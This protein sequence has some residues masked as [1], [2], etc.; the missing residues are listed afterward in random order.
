MFDPVSIEIVCCTY[1]LDP[2]FSLEKTSKKKIEIAYKILSELHNLIT[3]GGTPEQF[4]DASNRFYTLIPHSFGI[5][6]A[7]ILGTVQEIKDKTDMLDSLVEIKPVYAVFGKADKSLSR[8]DYH[9]ESI[10]SKIQPL[11]KSSNEF[12]VIAQYAKSSCTLNVIDIF[13]VKQQGDA[14]QNIENRTLLWYCG[15]RLT[16][17]GILLSQ[18]IKFPSSYGPKSCEFVEKGIKFCDVSTNSTFQPLT[19]TTGLLL[20]F[21]VALGE[22]L[23][24]TERYLF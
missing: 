5:D 20:L 19:T 8:V 11:K 3:N 14:H 15:T 24:S 10:N 1:G 12:S 22:I 7:S 18:G 6:G 2:K 21:E 9:Y 16:N 13:R 23:A 4:I 17:L